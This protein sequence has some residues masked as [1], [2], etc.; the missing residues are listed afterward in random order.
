MPKKNSNVI[1]SCLLEK[2]TS[3]SQ[4]T[5][6]TLTQTIFILLLLSQ[7]YHSIRKT[8]GLSLGSLSQAMTSLGSLSLLK[9]SIK[10]FV[11]VSGSL[12]SELSLLYLWSH[13]SVF[14]TFKV[15]G[16][17]SIP[18]KH[19][20]PPGYHG[21]HVSIRKHIHVHDDLCTY[22]HKMFGTHLSYSRMSGG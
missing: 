11:F 9:W 14:L 17:L 15:F 10:L 19:F 1:L 18:Q 21:N 8:Q 20:Q 12:V 2:I 3:R 7:T 16:S 13:R 4:L 6:F 5:L 22:L